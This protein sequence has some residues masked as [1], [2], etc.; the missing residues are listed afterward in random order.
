MMWRH[1]ESLMAGAGALY[2]NFDTESM[3]NVL[4]PA[5]SGV[6]VM[7]MMKS[8]YEQWVNIQ[9]SYTDSRGKFSYGLENLY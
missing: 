8:P 3:Q 4:Q 1:A 2:L 7:K 9:S 6:V 5:R